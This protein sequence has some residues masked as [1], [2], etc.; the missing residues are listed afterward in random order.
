MKFVTHNAKQD[1]TPKSSMVS[2][3]NEKI[4]GS[5]AVKDFHHPLQS[6]GRLG[7]MI[8]DRV[9]DLGVA[10]M[11]YVT[12]H[13]MKMIADDGLPNNILMFLSL[14]DEAL[15][16]AKEIYGWCLKK[17][18]EELKALNILVP[19]GTELFAPV[20]R[21]TSMRDAYAFRQHVEAA[22]RNR[23]VEMIA[24]FD[25]F[26]VFYFTNHQAVIGP[27]PMEVMPEHLKKLD[28]ELEA[29]IVI[30]KEGRN[31]KAE[32]A[33]D[34]IFGYMVMNDW[35]ARYLQM[36]EMKLSLGPAKGKDFATAIGPYL[37]TKDELAS[38]RIPSDKGD[39]YDL[40]MTC[41]IGNE[42]V[43]RGNLKDM[44]WTF[45]E[46][47]ERASYGVTLYPGDVIGSGTVGTGC[48]L[49]LNGSKVYDNRWI[50]IGDEVTCSVEM[51]G[52]LTNQVVAMK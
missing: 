18:D 9:A 13:D 6:K 49:E 40:A 3:F 48:L 2:E 52:D 15:A 32:N 46:I 24:E 36:E 41:R 11:R 21:P 45:A 1:L 35:S 43:S 22:R 29:C 5:K 27:G 44:S 31:I 19:E 37:V 51:L 30:G 7:F 28:F 42:E 20:P 16:K 23:G 17:T 47:I 12:H 26:P 33:D 38:R 10:A 34:H 39:R 8:G 14:G 50:Q 4:S 25:L